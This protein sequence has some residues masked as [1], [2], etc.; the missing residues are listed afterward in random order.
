M[1][2]Q[3]DNPNPLGNPQ[4]LVC[5]NCGEGVGLVENPTEEQLASIQ[6]FKDVHEVC[7]KETNPN[8]DI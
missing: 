3:I 4:I 2:K 5:D 1:I 8:L 7:S 6:E